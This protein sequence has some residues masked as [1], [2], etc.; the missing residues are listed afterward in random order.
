M[1]AVIEDFEATYDKLMARKAAGQPVTPADLYKLDRYWRT[2][3]KLSKILDN[4]QDKEAQLLSKNFQVQYEG[5]YKIFSLPHSDNA[6][7]ALDDANIQQIINQVWCADGKSWSDRVWQN[8]QALKQKLNDKLVTCVAV[9]RN[10]TQLKQELMETF[11]V[12]YNRAS[13]LVRTEMA[14]IQTEAAANRYKDYGIKQVEVLADDAGCDYCARLNG[15]RYSVY[16]K[17]PVPAHPNC[18][19]CIIPVIDDVV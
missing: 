5:I 9:G 15:K 11:N 2:Q 16:A 14:H 18:R 8:T 19:C 12:S 10:T 1:E 13:T 4:F 3:A 17:M 6:F 7:A